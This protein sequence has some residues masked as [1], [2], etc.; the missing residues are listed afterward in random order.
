M[1]EE[2]EKKTGENKINKKAP[3]FGLA[4]G[5][6]VPADLN[7]PSDLTPA[8]RVPFTLLYLSVLSCRASKRANTLQST[9]FI[10]PPV[11]TAVKRCD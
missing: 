4:G 7:S 6:S 11:A 9:G 2:E 3:R 8:G 1:T 5:D 10:N